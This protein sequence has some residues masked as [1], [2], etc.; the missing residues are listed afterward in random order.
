MAFRRT[1][2][3]AANRRGAAAIEYA[4][5]L[6]V[7]LLFMLGIID[8]GRLMWTYTTLSRAV[9]A[10]ARCGAINA[11]A[12]SPTACQ[13]NAAIQARAVT[14]AWGLTITS[15]AFTVTRPSCGVQVRG[16][17]SFVSIIP[18]IGRPAPMGTLALSATACYPV[19]LP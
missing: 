8:V 18:G 10:A 16:A 9:D 12:A 1:S 19:K 4:L 14:E 2:R 6:P 11:D 17:Y 3:L 5:L 13:S 7:L 15:A